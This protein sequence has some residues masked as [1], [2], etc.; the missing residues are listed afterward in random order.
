V[1]HLDADG[2]PCKHKNPCAQRSHLKAMCQ[3]CHLR[4]DHPRHMANARAT[5]EAKNP[6]LRMQL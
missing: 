3:R 5:R 2:G 1:A 6:Q 4:Y